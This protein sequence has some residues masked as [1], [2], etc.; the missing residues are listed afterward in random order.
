MLRS[1]A[2]DQKEKPTL[3]CHLLP[4][5]EVHKKL[6]AEVHKKLIIQDN[7]CKYVDSYMT[8]SFAYYIHHSSDTRSRF[9]SQS[10]VLY[11]QESRTF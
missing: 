10:I 8:V 4:V 9:L 7:L 1:V 3:R 2:I 6:I 5:A 11:N